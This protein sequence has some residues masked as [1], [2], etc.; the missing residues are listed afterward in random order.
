MV[1]HWGPDDGLAISRWEHWNIEEGSSPSLQILLRRMVWST[2]LKS[3]D[4]E[5]CTRRGNSRLAVPGATYPGLPG[6]ATQLIS[7]T[8]LSADLP[9]LIVTFASLFP[10][11]HG[12]TAGSSPSPKY[13][14]QSA[15]N[16]KSQC[17]EDIDFAEGLRHDRESGDLQA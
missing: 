5:H 7:V 15:H 6:P 4:F 1:V 2:L 8:G 13:Q 11:N 9:R 16:W 10:H 3:S 17:G 14:V 12:S